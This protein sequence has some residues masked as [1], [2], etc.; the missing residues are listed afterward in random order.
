MR[1]VQP[2]VLFIAVTASAAA[3]ATPARRALDGG[4]FPVDSSRAVE[5][6]QSALVG[7]AALRAGLLPRLEA[8]TRDSLG[9]VLRFDVVPA[10]FAGPVTVH[11]PRWEAAVRLT[12]ADG[13]VEMIAPVKPLRP[14]Q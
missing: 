6:G 14:R 1:P 11:V 3:C 7:S 12:G 2:R 10:G 9:F 5:I 4:P 8:F 13:G